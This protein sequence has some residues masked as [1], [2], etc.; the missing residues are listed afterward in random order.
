MLGA[1]GR[2]LAIDGDPVGDPVGAA[3][4]TERVYDTR[5]AGLGLTI[6]GSLLVVSAAAELGVEVWLLRRRAR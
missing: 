6:V 4:Q 3:A 5:P 1:G 2:A